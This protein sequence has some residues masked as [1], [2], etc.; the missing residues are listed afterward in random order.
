MG[1]AVAA[2]HLPW[3]GAAG[4]GGV[5]H[6]HHSGGGRSTYASPP[7]PASPFGNHHQPSHQHLSPRRPGGGIAGLGPPEILRAHYRDLSVEMSA[8]LP[9][10]DPRLRAVPPSYVGAFPLDADQQDD[11]HHH[12]QQQQQRPRSSFGYPGTT[13]RVRSGEDGRLYCLRRYDSVRCVSHKIAGAVRDA[14]VRAPLIDPSD[15]G[16][17]GGSA[18]DP[19]RPTSHGGGGRGPL[20]DHP[21][22]VRLYRAF[23]SQRAVFFVHRYHPGARTMRER[24]GLPRRSGGGGGGGTATGPNGMGRNGLEPV[25]EAMIWDCASQLTSAVRAVHAAGLACR[26]LQL[27]HVLCVPEGGPDLPAEGGQTDDGRGGG[28]ALR[29]RINCLGVVDALEFET[30]HAVSD[31]HGDDVRA[32]GRIVLSLA[33]GCVCAPSLGRLFPFAS[34]LPYRSAY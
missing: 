23:V 8:E 17:G 26:T 27:E 1:G 30:R 7:A 29:L 15:P 25:P 10:D 5:G 4:D 19:D 11:R 2:S 3:H 28:G 14:W 13:F 20:L 6:G 34:P 24:F 12:H 22:L 21:G 16:A 33:T 31:L 32:L 18:S 9:P